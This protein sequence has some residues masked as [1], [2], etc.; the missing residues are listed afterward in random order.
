MSKNHSL[1]ILF[2]FFIVSI[3]VIVLGK[4]K[5]YKDLEEVNLQLKWYHQFQFAG[6][7]AASEKGFY[8]DAGLK[9][10]II[11]GG[12]SI[13][14]SDE[15]CSG[16]ADFGVLGPE[17]VLNRLNGKGLVLLAVIFQHSANALMV[18]ATSQIV[19]PTD[20]IGKKIMLTIPESAE[21]QAM[22]AS[23]SVPWKKLSI[24]NKDES[25]I[26]K[27]I[28]GEI[29]AINGY[30]NNEPFLFNQI[31]KPVHIIRPLEYGINFFGDALYTSDEYLY[32]HPNQVAKFREATLKGWNYALSNIDEIIDL[33]LK[34]YNPNKKRDHLKYESSIISTLILSE[35]VKL[36]YINPRVVDRIVK[37]ITEYNLTSSNRKIN[38]MD[39]FIYKPIQKD[40]QSINLTSEEKIWLK[41]HPKITLGFNPHMEPIVIKNND[42]TM[43][44]MYVDLYN[45]INE[46]LG[47]NIQ[48][49]L[50]DWPTVI[51]KAR[52][53]EI[54]GIL[55]CGPDLAKEHNLL[56]TTSIQDFYP[57][58]FS[59]NDG[60]VKVK[61]LD[62]IVGKKIAY[63]KGVKA[64][65][66]ILN[67][68]KGKCSVIPVTSTLEALK[69]VLENKADLAM[70]LSFENY[71]I[72]KHTLAGIHVEHI[73]IS[74]SSDAVTAIRND[75][76]ILIN[77]L[78]KALKKI[79]PEKTQKLYLKW[80]QLP[81]KKSVN[82]TPDEQKWIRNNP[83]FKISAT[84]L[85]PY[86]M[87]E[88]GIVTGYM[89]DLIRAICSKTNLIPNFIFYEYHKD[90]MH[91]LTNG[92]INAATAK[93]ANPELAKFLLFSNET[94]PL[95]MAI[96]ALKDKD[97]LNSLKALKGKKI[98]TYKL[99]SINNMLKQNFPDSCLLIADNPVGMMQLVAT[100]KADAAIQ[101]QYTGLHI[102]RKNYINVLEVKGFANFE[103]AEN[104]KG[105]SYAVHKNFPL[106]KSILDKGYEALTRNELNELYNK[107]MSADSILI[108][109]KEIELTNEERLWLKEHPVIRVG[110][111]PEWGPIEYLTK[112]GTFDGLSVD[113]LKKIEQKLN[114]QFEFVNQNWQGLINLAK[115]KEIDMFSC[116]ARTSERDSYLNFTSPYIEIPTG[117]FA[118]EDV[119]YISNI[120]L[121]KG[122][123]VA[124]VE[125]YAIHNYMKNNF[126]DI[127]LILVKT[128]KEGLKSVVKGKAFAYI[129]NILILG[130]IIRNTGYYNIKMVGESPFVNIQRMGIR[131]DWPIFRD[132]MQ[133]AINTISEEERNNIYN[134]WAPLIHE[135]EI[136]Y[137]LFW[138][139]GAGIVFII[140]FILFWNRS[141]AKQ[142]TLRT[143]DLKASEKKYRG[144]Y[145]SLQDGYMK[146]DLNGNILLANQ[147]A[148]DI[149]GYNLKELM[150]KD[151]AKELYYDSLDRE[152]LMEIILQTKK[153]ENY[154]IKAKH[155]NGS[156]VFIELSS[157]LVYENKK[158]IAL[159]STFRDI[160]KRK[161]TEKETARLASVIYQSTDDIIIT[162]TD[163]FIIYVNPAFEK[164]FGYNFSEVT[165]K[166]LDLLKSDK[167]KEDFLNTIWTTIKNGNVWIGDITNKR[168]DESLI[169]EHTIMFPIFDKSGE[170][171]NY[172]S[173]SRDMTE[174]Q[175][176]ES[177]LRQAQKMEAIGTLAGG[178]AHDFNNI[179]SAII[180]FTEISL[181]DIPNDSELHS[182]LQNVL[183]A[184][185]RAKDLVNQILTF[186][187][188][189]EQEL[190]PLK[191]QIVINEALKLIRSSL[192]STIEIRKDIDTNC[193]P[194][195]VDPTQIH[196]IIMNLCTN[197]YHAMKES[198]GIIEVTLKAL[199]IESDSDILQKTQ[200]KPGQ[201]LELI[202]KDTG[203]GISKENIEKIFDPYFTTKEKG[204]G[205]GLGLSTVHG[206]IMNFNGDI[207]VE[208][209][210]NKGTS[211]IIYLP[212]IDDQNKP[213]DNQNTAGFIPKGNERIL[214]VDDDEGTLQL[215]NKLLT[216]LGYNVTS[217]I[218]SIK[219]I[220][221][222]RDNPDQFDLIITDMTMPKI[223]GIEL[224]SQVLNIANDIPIILCSGYSDIVNNEKAKEMG[225]KEYIMKPVI[226]KD[227][228]EAIRRALGENN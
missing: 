72:S 159:E 103:E 139:I 152:K 76:P 161:E 189:T 174:Y 58:I 188:Q 142:V 2:L 122:K 113:Y 209:E 138:K 150:S 186:S 213:L 8:K 196:Q 218:N 24:I 114:I 16:N 49:E 92:D 21:F 182:D 19:N 93:I 88:D 78:N 57:I 171:I 55:G 223:T 10:N 43:S 155:K 73:D 140:L 104:L 111:D 202:V 125:E 64:N 206:I 70:G 17:A 66:N 34:K 29:D 40:M 83:H 20:F 162:D 26:S 4:Q 173:V 81:I 84:S 134:K 210:I 5:Q 48:I 217:E 132:I 143:L 128:P 1:F 195:L 62:D 205:T 77:I 208:S 207:K 228:A 200:L 172:A 166:H 32:K 99:Y 129:D 51:K 11:E 135:Q 158:P 44:G 71:L 190:R 25:A 178:I 184:G 180:G 194:V 179:L 123:K 53:R 86:V 36:G 82:L 74:R 90:A 110:S 22:F 197:A 18:D 89:S 59:R 95:N 120:N 168:K 199:N 52:K 96:F 167:H 101:E 117:I 154:E 33:I 79:G 67:L 215:H 41:N 157:H 108:T 222:F 30:I 211:F 146:A 225:I 39:G 56:F 164:N 169:Q 65:E 37:K 87:K 28:S 100:G 181:E 107:W 61:K 106:L 12:S 80:M 148:A 127:D 31:S 137:S 126:P 163:G 153:V 119:S 203:Y 118:K 130:H 219:A 221:I 216:R 187:R 109:N 97:S 121:L 7:Y 160:T 191:I 151:I 147:F 91:A 175:K 144:I 170:I 23:E 50:Y 45:D 183:I 227:M 156:L 226:K 27:L 176:L 38:S 214:L 75:W 98:A 212:V 177:Q 42:G 201:H 54:D 136:D 60:S 145:E 102:I 69:L 131:K 204:E 9:V 193:A 14:V 94:M 141:L 35:L 112:D 115:E 15:I 63:Q 116:I 47:T 6:Y 13:N 224:A 192:P 133:K 185:G 149:L 68:Y 85:P 46:I 220:E 165:N 3:N 198:G 105:H 124:V